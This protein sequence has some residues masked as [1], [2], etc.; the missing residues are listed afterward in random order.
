ME[1]SGDLCQVPFV[2]IVKEFCDNINSF[3]A[4]Q[5]KTGKIYVFLSSAPVYV[6]LVKLLLPTVK[7]NGG[8]QPISIE[9]KVAHGSS[10]AMFRT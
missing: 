4:I 2:S 1:I 5:P 9:Y 7:L 8:S 10:P 3:M 6:L